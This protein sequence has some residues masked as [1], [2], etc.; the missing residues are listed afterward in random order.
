MNFDIMPE[1]H[2]TYGYGYVY[3][4]FVGVVL[5]AVLLMWYMGLIKVGPGEKGLV[6]WIVGGWV[7]RWVG[8]W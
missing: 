8:G 7:S 4:L 3:G 5:L 6:E 1:L 2:W